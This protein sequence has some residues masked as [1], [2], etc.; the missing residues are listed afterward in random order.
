L[1]GFD[2]RQAMPKSAPN[3]PSF[4]AQPKMRHLRA[5]QA[6]ARQLNFRAAAQHLSVSQP[7]LSTAIRE[8]ETLLGATLFER[9]PHR[10]ELTAEGA[11]LLPQAEWLL[12]NF[13]H[14]VDDM[15]RS[16][17]ELSHS[18]RVGVLPSMM[19]IVTPELAVWR[20]E[21]PTVR[22]MIRDLVN[23]N[24]IA[25]LLAGEIDLAVGSDI[26]LPEQLSAVQ[27]GK[28]ALV[29]L[30]AK[31]HPLA[32]RRTVKWSELEGETLALFEN[33]STYDLALSMLKQKNLK[34]NIAYEL[35]F[36]ESIFSL[37]RAG[38]GIGIVS[39][40]YTHDAAEKG[41]VTVHLTH[42]TID[43]PICVM[44]RQ[45]PSAVKLVAGSCYHHLVKAL[46]GHP[47]FSSV[48][49]Q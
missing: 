21:F 1:I 4:S 37:T 9:G 3:V 6:V 40:L 32:K 10:V 46:N 15:R 12:N 8:L 26:E 39:N 24:L 38:L 44:R 35:L 22:L 25:A 28:D 5:F 7:A 49:K 19:H 34:L 29:A 16:L 33:A 47:G 23:R 41:L 31:E 27:V 43:R 30:V 20:R 13:N 18:L 11:R 45:G 42:P 14:G 48:P 2:Y 17:T 36:R